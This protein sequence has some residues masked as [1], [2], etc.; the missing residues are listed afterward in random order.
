MQTGESASWARVGSAPLS[1]SSWTTC[2]CRA[3]MVRALEMS[4]CRGVRWREGCRGVQA[5]GAAGQ[6]EQLPG[7]LEVAQGEG[8]EEWGYSLPVGGVW[9]VQEWR[10]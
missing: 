10:A 5:V 7:A 8:E 9:G 1:S 2:R 3:E 4:S 6:G